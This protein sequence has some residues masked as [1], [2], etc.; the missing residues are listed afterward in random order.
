MRPEIQELLAARSFEVEGKNGAEFQK[1]ID[2]DTVK[3]QKV[4]TAA[5]IRED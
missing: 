3:W 5:K 2:R 4:I 1:I